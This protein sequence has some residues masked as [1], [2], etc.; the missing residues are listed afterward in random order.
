VTRND[1]KIVEWDSN[2][3]L[4]KINPLIN[5]SEQEVKEYIEAR[6]IPVSPL[7]Q[8]GFASIG[9]QPCTRAIEAGENV[10]AGRWWWET[11]ETK[12]CGLH[13]R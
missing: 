3:G 9:C 4:V 13:K 6:G 5:W 7:H 8:Q 12:E 1:I 11:P 10:R 2:N